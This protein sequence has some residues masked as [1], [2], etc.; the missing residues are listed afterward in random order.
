MLPKQCLPELTY[1]DFTLLFFVKNTEDFLQLPL[2]FVFLHLVGDKVLE[3]IE[4]DVAGTC[5]ETITD[6]HAA[7][8]YTL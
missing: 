5:L 4:L 3:L 6:I 7:C 1:V 8:T 2:V